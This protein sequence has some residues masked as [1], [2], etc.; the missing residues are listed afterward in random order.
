MK[1]R[2]NEQNRKRVLSPKRKI[3]RKDCPKS[4]TNTVKTTNGDLIVPNPTLAFVSGKKRPAL[5]PF[6]NVLSQ[7]MSPHPSSN[8]ENS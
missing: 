8:K 6:G 1:L 3:N 7:A 5:D 4:E 2:S